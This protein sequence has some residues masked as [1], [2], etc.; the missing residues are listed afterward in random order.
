MQAH[1]FAYQGDGHM[2]VG[3]LDAV[4]QGPPLRQIGLAA[5]Q[6]QLAAH[7]VAQALAGQQQGH[8]IQGG[9]GKVLDDAVRLYI[10]E[11]GDLVADVLGDGAVRAAD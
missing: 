4:H 5:A 11:Q 1:I 6:G 9:G 10:A 2:A 8:L 3:L 7:H